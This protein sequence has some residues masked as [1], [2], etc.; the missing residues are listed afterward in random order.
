MLPIFLP[1]SEEAFSQ[2]RVA[3]TGL[4]RL[5]MRDQGSGR[6]GAEVAAGVG[7][8]GGGVGR[9]IGRLVLAK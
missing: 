8:E 4:A 9:I 1:N 3:P 5:D 2:F 6:A 7:A